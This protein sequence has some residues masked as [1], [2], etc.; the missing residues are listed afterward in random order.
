MFYSNRFR[1]LW[2]SPTADVSVC[3]TLA[4]FGSRTWAFRFFIFSL[5]MF[6]RLSFCRSRITTFLLSFAEI[7]FLTSA[8][9]GIADLRGWRLKF[10][11]EANRRL[12]LR[13]ADYKSAALP[14]K[15]KSHWCREIDLNYQRRPCFGFTDRPLNHSSIPANGVSLGVEP[16]YTGHSRTALH[17]KAHNEFLPVLYPF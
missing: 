13:T 7:L 3:L 17:R 9:V 4:F 14:V 15:L 16:N 2:A 5:M 8:S 11:V 1:N 12:E 10:E 6:L